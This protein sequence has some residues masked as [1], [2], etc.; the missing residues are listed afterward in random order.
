MSKILDRIWEKSIVICEAGEGVIHMAHGRL[1]NDHD[2]MGLSN[3]VSQGVLAVGYDHMTAVV[4]ESD[5]AV[6]SLR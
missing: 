5:D 6:I 2:G 3:G 1:R 4:G